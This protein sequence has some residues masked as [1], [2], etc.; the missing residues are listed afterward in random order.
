MGKERGRREEEEE[1]KHS[2]VRGQY[3]RRSRGK[4]RRHSAK[5]GEMRGIITRSGR[6][7]RRMPM[8][9]IKA[10]TISATVM[11]DVDKLDHRH[12]S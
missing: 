7:Y 11:G 6:Q 10:P 3:P 4:L 8:P 1:S 9:K 5:G 12:A 2:G